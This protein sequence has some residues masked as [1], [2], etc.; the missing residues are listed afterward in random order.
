MINARLLMLLDAGRNAAVPLRTVVRLICSRV[1][2][3]SEFLSAKL[4]DVK[5]F[6]SSHE[7]NADN[8]KLDLYYEYNQQ[9]SNWFRDCFRR[10]AYCLSPY[11]E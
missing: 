1:F 3:A 5:H 7:T 8:L 10:S 6:L 11:G 2:N 4:Q 9:I